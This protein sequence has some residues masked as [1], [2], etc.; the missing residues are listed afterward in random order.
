MFGA[1]VGD[2]LGSI[3][4]QT[5]QRPPDDWTTAVGERRFTSASILTVATAQALLDG[6]SCREHYAR[7]IQ[8]FPAAG[9]GQDLRAWM[10]DEHR[11]ELDTAAA[12]R[13]SPIGWGSPRPDEVHRRAKDISSS[14]SVDIEQ[15]VVVGGAIAIAR[16]GHHLERSPEEIG[17]AMRE[18]AR[19]KTDHSLLEMQAPS[20]SLSALQAPSGVVAIAALQGCSNFE[21]ALHNALRL[22]R[23]QERVVSVAGALAEATFGGVPESLAAMVWRELP[24]QLQAVVMR[25]WQGT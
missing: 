15:A 10:R 17:T 1:I 20:R 9:Y 22:H 3:Y 18:Y 19:T 21:E 12:L 2:F 14:S 24:S 8:R 23:A 6:T 13:A 11:A 25:F 4:E 7:W 16:E 5:N